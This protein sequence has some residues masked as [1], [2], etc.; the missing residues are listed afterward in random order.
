VLFSLELLVAATN[1]RRLLGDVRQ[2]RHS[3]ARPKAG[4]PSVQSP[5][6]ALWMIDS[7]LVVVE[8]WRADAWGL[9]GN[10]WSTH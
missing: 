4:A 9:A 3:T 10:H 6:H 1:E 7:G 8:D 5:I 2:W